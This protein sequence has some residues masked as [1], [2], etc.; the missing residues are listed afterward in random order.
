MPDQVRPYS[1]LSS[2]PLIQ[3]LNDIAVDVSWRDRPTIYEAVKEIEA[4]IAY[5]KMTDQQ[6]GHLGAAIERLEKEITRNAAPNQLP[7]L[8]YNA[9]CECCQRNKITIET[10]K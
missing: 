10:F 7:K 8:E 3:R 5:I 9:H 6:I 1:E 2:R 4:G